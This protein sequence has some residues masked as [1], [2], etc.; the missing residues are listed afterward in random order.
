[1][2]NVAR[3]IV[4]SDNVVWSWCPF[5]IPLGLS[6]SES[7]AERPEPCAS[8]GR[9]VPSSAAGGVAGDNRWRCGWRY[10]WRQM[11]LRVAPLEIVHLLLV[12]ECIGR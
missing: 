3:P 12:L 7:A 9:P 5:P 6:A 8:T 4:R 10:G 1:M 11:A 2:C